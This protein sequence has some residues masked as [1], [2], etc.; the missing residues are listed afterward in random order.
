MPPSALTLSLSLSQNEVKEEEDGA[1][2]D[3][4]EE[5]VQTRIEE[6]NAQVSEDGMKLVSLQD[7]LAGAINFRLTVVPDFDEFQLCR[8][9][10]KSQIN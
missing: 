5:E 9:L 2:K 3:L 8:D 1:T 10:I 4:S 7:T 6:Y